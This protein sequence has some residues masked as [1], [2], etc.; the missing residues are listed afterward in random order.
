MLSIKY[1]LYYLILEMS[2]AVCMYACM[3]ANFYW[4]LIE[5]NFSECITINLR[6]HG[7]V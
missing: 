1:N 7:F 3:H 5:W 2:V 4:Y 6:L